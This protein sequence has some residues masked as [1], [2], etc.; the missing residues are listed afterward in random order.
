ML[1]C[2]YGVAVVIGFAADKRREHLSNQSLI[3]QPSKEGS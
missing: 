3:G 2:I 1:G